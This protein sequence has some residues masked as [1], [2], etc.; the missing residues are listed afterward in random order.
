[1]KNNSNLE[2]QPFEFGSE[3]LSRASVLRGG[4]HVGGGVGLG[5]CGKSFGLGLHVILGL[6]SVSVSSFVLAR[7]PALVGKRF[8][9]DLL[10]FSADVVLGLTYCEQG[11]LPLL[12][13]QT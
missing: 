12:L 11:K 5:R 8:S 6:L 4:T 13:V 3:A 10:V 1:M 9:A 2:R 7:H